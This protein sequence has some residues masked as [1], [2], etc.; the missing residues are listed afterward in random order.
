MKIIT[1]QF[2]K[3]QYVISYPN[4]YIEN[5]RYPVIFHTHGAGSRGTDLSALNIDVPIR[6]NPSAEDFIIVAP[7]CY[8]DTW[9]EIFRSEAH[10]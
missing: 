7:Q 4:N 1:R 5:K 8:V 2:K 6:N 10:V 3:L 9:F